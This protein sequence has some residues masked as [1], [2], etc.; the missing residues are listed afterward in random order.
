ME[1]Y[2]EPTG[3]PPTR[4]TDAHVGERD[5]G[6][7]PPDRPQALF[8]GD[9]RQLSGSQEHIQVRERDSQSMGAASSLRNSVSSLRSGAST[10][11]STGSGSAGVGATN[12]LLVGVDS[13]LLT[14]AGSSGSASVRREA[15]ET[16]EQVEGGSQ[17]PA[18]GALSLIHI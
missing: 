5:G 9:K 14:R 2:L 7:Y 4:G 1:V 11:G 17:L 18:V 15:L 8:Y 3:A 6:N 13:D 12:G 16:L 10:P